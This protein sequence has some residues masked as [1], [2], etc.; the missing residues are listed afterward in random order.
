LT[1]QEL[2]RGVTAL[3][4]YLELPEVM[5]PVTPPVTGAWARCGNGRATGTERA[6]PSRR[7]CGWNLA[8][9]RPP[10]RCGGCVEGRRRGREGPR[11]LHRAEGS[12]LQPRRKPIGLV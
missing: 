12:G 3:R 6:R 9:S 11:P 4:R 5:R 2:E 8:S 1:G 10:R 7:P